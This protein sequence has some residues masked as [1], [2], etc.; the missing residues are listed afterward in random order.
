MCMECK[1]C[2]AT[3]NDTDVFCSSCGH[4]VSDQTSDDSSDVAQK[5][6]KSRNSFERRHLLDNL[7]VVM[8][9]FYIAA[10]VVALFYLQQFFVEDWDSY[11]L[12]IIFA[13]LLISATLTACVYAVLRFKHYSD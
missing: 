12:A 6:R 5:K 7:Q 4:R 3:L 11:A 10:V 2:G 13:S 8:A 1:Q 9:V